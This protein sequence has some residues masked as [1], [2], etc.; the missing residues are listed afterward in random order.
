MPLE[1]L[2]P[3][4]V[5]LVPSLCK[6]IFFLM[7]IV[8]NCFSLISYQIVYNFFFKIGRG[9]HII[10]CKHELVFVFASSCDFV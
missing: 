9:I 10:F 3:I 8:L 4:Q 1:R 7:E 2:V 5:A 6:M